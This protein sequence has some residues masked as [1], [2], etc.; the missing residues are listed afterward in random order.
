[1]KKTGEQRADTM[2][3]LEGTLD[4]LVKTL[5]VA[6]MKTRDIETCFHTALATIQELTG[7]NRGNT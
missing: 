6:G 4:S 5:I 1:M 7:S 3:A 2:F